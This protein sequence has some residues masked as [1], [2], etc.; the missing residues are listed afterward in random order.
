MILT[1]YMTTSNIMLMGMLLCH[2]TGVIVQ[3]VKVI[4]E[5]GEKLKVSET[6]VHKLTA[7]NRYTL[8]III[9]DVL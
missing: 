9:I 8:I 1:H 6:Y 7:Q 4:E 5:L 3:E 2:S